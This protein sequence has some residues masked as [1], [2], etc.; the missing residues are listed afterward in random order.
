[1]RFSIVGSIKEV[2]YNWFPYKEESEV[3]VEESEDSNNYIYTLNQGNNEFSDNPVPFLNYDIKIPKIGVRKLSEAEGEYMATYKITEGGVD[4]GSSINIPKEFLVKSAN[5]L[6]CETDDV[7]VEGYVVGDKYI[8]FE[9]NSSS[10][11]SVEHLYLLVSDLVNG[12]D[13][14]DITIE[15]SQNNVFKVKDNGITLN[16]LNNDQRGQGAA[17]YILLF[18]GVIVIAIAAILIYSSYF[19]NKSSDLN[20]SQD[21]NTIRENL[22]ATI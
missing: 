12:Y 5:I 8:D 16:K 19:G 15:L 2:V 11:S 17:E 20:A 9:I 13:C 18:G 7:P 1:M 6:V 14:D 21:I 22:S 10:E 4:V 3:S